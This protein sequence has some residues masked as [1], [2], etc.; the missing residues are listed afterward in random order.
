[1]AWAMR[2]LPSMLKGSVTTATVSTLA[3]AD[4]FVRY[5]IFLP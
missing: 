1:M 5:R 2:R 4:D 3:K